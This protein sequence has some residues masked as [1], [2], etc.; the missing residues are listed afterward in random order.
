MFASTCP[1]RNLRLRL[2][3]IHYVAGQIQLVLQPVCLVLQLGRPGW[4]GVPYGGLV[5]VL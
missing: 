3:P 1:G 4:T 5:V 2:L